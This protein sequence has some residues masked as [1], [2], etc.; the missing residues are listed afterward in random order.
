MSLKIYN[1]RPIH[2]QFKILPRNILLT[3]NY[4]ITQKIGEKKGETL[5]RK[6]R[7]FRTKGTHKHI[8][9]TLSL[10]HVHA[11]TLFLSGK[12]SVIVEI[13]QWSFQVFV[14][15][16]HPEISSLSS[17]SFPFLFLFFML[18]ILQYFSFHL[19]S[20]YLIISK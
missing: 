12:T 8:A 13:S 5:T 9:A 20:N 4:L 3:Y 18:S 17:K 15:A 19:V 2:Q 14:C 16:F 11:H 7:H 10:L 1:F 6:W